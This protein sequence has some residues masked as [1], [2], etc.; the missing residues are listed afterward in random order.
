[1]ALISGALI[2]LPFIGAFLAVVPPLLL[3][4]VVSPP[5]QLLIKL[6]IVGLLLGAAQHLVL[7]VLAPRIFGQHMN[8]PTLVLF[9][10]LL[11]GA[12]EGGV[13]GAF[14]AGP[15]VA[16]GY[17]MFEV[18][19]ERFSA[20]SPLF[21][22]DDFDDESNEDRPDEAAASPPTPRAGR[23]PP[24]PGSGMSSYAPSDTLGASEAAHPPAAPANGNGQRGAPRPKRTR[25][26]NGV[27]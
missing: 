21:Q 12:G 1:V 5:E 23:W 19:Y 26:V 10:A 6:A 7:N 13:W 3:V 9:A 16:V 15:V 20:G 27:E 4:A 24:I 8:V 25:D 22:S 11:L 18:F 2:W 14:F 17:A